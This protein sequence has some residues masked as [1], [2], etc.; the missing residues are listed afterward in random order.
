M[1]MLKYDGGFRWNSWWEEAKNKNKWLFNHLLFLSDSLQGV[2]DDHDD[3]DD[4]IN[5]NLSVDQLYFWSYYGFLS[6]RKAKSQP[7]P[8]PA[9]VKV[10]EYDQ[11]NI[12][13]RNNSQR[14]MEMT[15]MMIIMMM[16]QLGCVWRGGAPVTDCRLGSRSHESWFSPKGNKRN[17]EKKSKTFLFNLYMYNRGGIKTC[18][19]GEKPSLYNRWNCLNL[20][21]F[22]NLH[23][24]PGA[25]VNGKEIFVPITRVGLQIQ[26]GRFPHTAIVQYFVGVNLKNISYSNI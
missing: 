11:L 19:P 17:Q 8:K 15:M 22:C 23:V 25:K 24:G 1:I 4:G 7:Y 5:D 13:L 20:S 18:S 26:R 21:L 10:M 12:V 16:E 3:D 2:D 14:V 6:Y 9:V